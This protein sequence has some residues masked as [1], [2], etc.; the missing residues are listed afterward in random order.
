MIRRRLDELRDVL[1]LE[2]VHMLEAPPDD[3]DGPVGL[4]DG[5]LLA[6]RLPAAAA[7]FAYFI[8]GPDP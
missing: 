4:I 3:W 2:L 1:D 7:R 8:C 5:E 6:A